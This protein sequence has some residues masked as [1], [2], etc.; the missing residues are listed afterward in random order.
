MK[1][2]HTRAFILNFLYKNFGVKQI[3]NP[4]VPK[5]DYFIIM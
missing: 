3:L 2:F 4:F 5:L 1:H